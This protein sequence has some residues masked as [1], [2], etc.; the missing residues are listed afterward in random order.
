MQPARAAPHS[1]T[2]WI[3]VEA[4]LGQAALNMPFPVVTSASTVG[5]PRES[6]TCRARTAEIAAG[7]MRENSAASAAHGSAA[8]ALTV[9]LTASSTF[10]EMSCLSMYSWI[11]AIAAGGWAIGPA[12]RRRRRLRRAVCRTAASTPRLRRSQ[13]QQRRSAAGKTRRSPARAK[14]K[15]NAGLDV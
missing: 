7:A 12:G 11:D 9:A 2:S 14:K 6:N 5:L 1:L 4:P 8:R 3:P 15:K 13:S 10:F